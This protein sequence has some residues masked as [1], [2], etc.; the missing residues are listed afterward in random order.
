MS[1]R[2]PKH[3]F[4]ASITFEKYVYGI[5]QTAIATAQTLQEVEYLASQYREFN[6]NV[7]IKENKDEYPKFNWV[8]VKEYNLFRGGL[9]HRER[10]GYCLRELRETA[11]ITVRDLAAN[12]GVTP[13]NITNI[14][15]GRYSAGLDVLERIAVALGASVNIVKA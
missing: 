13:A 4:S 6:P 11:G 10:I 3:K 8:K 2:S 1:T 15:N 7:L 14:E 12:A 5:G 9:A